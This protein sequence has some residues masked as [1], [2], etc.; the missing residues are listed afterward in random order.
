MAIEKTITTTMNI[1][2]T[3][4]TVSGKFASFN[5]EVYVPPEIQEYARNVRGDPRFA[6]VHTIAMSD[7][8]RYG[9]NLNGDIFRWA[10][11][12]GIQSA[13]ESMKNRG[14]L[15]GVPIP[16]YKTFE[17][18]KFYRHHANSPIDPHYGDIPLAVA[19]E[20]MR[21]IE[22]II[23]IFKVPFEGGQAANDIVR[24]MDQRGYLTGSMGCRIHHEK[25]LYCGNENEF[26][27]DRC[28]C[29][30]NHMNEIMP[31]G[32]L[33]AADNYEPHFFDYSDVT[34]PADPIAS[35]LSKVAS[36]QVHGSV[37]SIKDFIEVLYW[38]S[39]Q[40]EM[41]KQVGAMPGTIGA[42]PV[43][44]P[45]CSTCEKLPVGRQIAP[46]TLKQAYVI[47]DDLDRFA[48]TLALAGVVMSPVELAFVTDL[49][50]QNKLASADTKFEGIK[51]LSLDNFSVFLYDF[52]RTKMADRMG[53]VS[54]CPMSGWEP[55]KIAESGHREVADYYSYYRRLLGSLPVDGF[56]KAANRNPLV[57][58]ILGKSSAE[59]HARVKGA[60]YHLAH[61]GMATV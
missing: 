30:K 58:E 41:D 29:L 57:R 20:P 21:R 18:A 26:V 9:S 59:K 36:A 44:V 43:D 32:Q 13:R 11:L 27:R 53:Y 1:E 28:D 10:E 14:P 19:N 12:L 6:H 61:A 38:R 51:N 16:R 22:L 52:V 56:M 39:K 8:E 47:V 49:S 40:G 54:A 2:R 60:M 5:P 15:H 48:S 55:T 46:E 42:I 50:E 45:P 17:Q 31:N 23:R 3:F 33:V 35:S 7:G 24:K 34:V 25:C 37:N 4:H